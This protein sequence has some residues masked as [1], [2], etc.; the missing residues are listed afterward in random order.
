[1]TQDDEIPA[2]PISLEG[3]R[4]Q[5][6]QA[7]PAPIVEALLTE[8]EGLR[9]LVADLAWGTHWHPGYPTEPNSSAVWIAA[10][11]VEIENKART[12]RAAVQAEI[13][14]DRA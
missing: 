4:Q 5:R 14:R 3:L 6:P 7:L 1:M 9:G 2:G 11:L 13:G 10:R 8:I 12:L